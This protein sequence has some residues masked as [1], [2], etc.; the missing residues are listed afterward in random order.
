MSILDEV[1]DVLLIDQ[2]RVFSESTSAEE[3][4]RELIQEMERLA[5]GLRNELSSLITRE[6]AIRSA[7][8]YNSSECELWNERASMAADDGLN[9]L[10]HE[11]LKW[12]SEH[13]DIIA[14]LRDDQTQTCDLL[15]V[16]QHK[17]AALQA[18]GAQAR[19]R[20]ELVVARK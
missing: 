16:L 19:R 7:L 8:A 12:K 1:R 9:L 2:S 17:L 14:S 18:A 11:A 3:S 20:L 4:L 5:D 13:E 6:E 10:T 15:N